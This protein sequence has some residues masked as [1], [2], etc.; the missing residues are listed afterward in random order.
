MSFQSHFL[1]AIPRPGFVIY[2]P[3]TVQSPDFEHYRESI[4]Q[5]PASRDKVLFS[6]FQILY[7]HTQLPIK[8]SYNAPSVNTILQP[9]RQE[10][11]QY[12]YKQCL[13]LIFFLFCQVQY[14]HI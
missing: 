4:Q 12:L 10:D 3:T 13:Y 7:T 6:P 5:H 14:V 9:H 1:R 8:H 11:Q 2:V